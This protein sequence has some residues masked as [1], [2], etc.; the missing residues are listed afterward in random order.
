MK[1]IEYKF[2]ENNHLYLTLPKLNVA[3]TEETKEVP[4]SKEIAIK[5]INPDKKSIIEAKKKDLR[6]VVPEFY[7]Y[8]D[9]VNKETSN[10]IDNDFPN[11]ESFTGKELTEEEQKNL[12]EKLRTKK[13]FYNK[14]QSN[15]QSM[16]LS[17]K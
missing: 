16:Q 9:T 4:P 7:N 12:F 11:D 8:D 6:I 3:S 2:D 13:R 17:K 5:K 10:N 1:L 15:S 14:E